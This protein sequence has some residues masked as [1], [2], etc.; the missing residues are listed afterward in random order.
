V[1]IL[2]GGTYLVMVVAEQ[3]IEDKALICL[4][5]LLSA[6]SLSHVLLH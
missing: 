2:C 3:E 4:S 1:A 6:C 5:S